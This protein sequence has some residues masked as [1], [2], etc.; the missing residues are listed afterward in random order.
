M[1]D[2][3]VTTGARQFAAGTISIGNYQYP[4]GLRLSLPS[5]SLRSPGQVIDQTPPL[6]ADDFDQPDWGAII[7]I[8]FLPGAPFC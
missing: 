5:P 6:N 7:E 1:D 4:V 3:L 8:A 2:R